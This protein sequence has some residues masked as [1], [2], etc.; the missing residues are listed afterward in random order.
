MHLTFEINAMILADS[1]LSS[2]NYNNERVLAMKRFHISLLLMSCA[3]PCMA[4]QTTPAIY[5]GSSLMEPGQSISV[6]TANPRKSSDHTMTDLF[7]GQISPLT[8]KLKDLNILW[9]SFNLPSGNEGKSEHSERTT[10]HKSDVFFTQGRTVRLNGA[11]YMIAYSLQNA[12]SSIVK[13]GNEEAKFKP[14]TPDSE[15][16]LCLLDM[17]SVKNILNISPFDLSNLLTTNEKYS[18]E[19][20]TS[21]LNQI[22]IALMMYTQDHEMTL[23]PMTDYTVFIKALYPYISQTRAFYVPG[24]HIPYSLNTELSKQKLSAI[25]TPINTVVIYEPHPRKDGARAVGFLDGH[26]SALDEKEWD[27][28]MNVCK[29]QIKTGTTR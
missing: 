22:L 24:T 16:H 5:P 20:S 28:F 26:V 4:M 25:Q 21:N 1:S 3:L 14:T 6:A 7:T 23:P 29:V 9:S 10:T 11:T 19:I 13:K 2:A 17:Q 12:Y 18:D 27:D 8:M 15:L